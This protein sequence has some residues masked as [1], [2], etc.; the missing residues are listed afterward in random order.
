M[1]DAYEAAM[2][3]YTASADYKV[4]CTQLDAIRIARDRF[5]QLERAHLAGGS[6]SCPECGH[7]QLGKRQECRQCGTKFA[8]PA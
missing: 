6:W 8:M 5:I 1:A 2:R 7:R 3:A 4:R